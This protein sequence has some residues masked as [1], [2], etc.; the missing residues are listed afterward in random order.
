MKAAS[1]GAL[2]ALEDVLSVVRGYAELTERKRGTFHRKS[3]AFL[4]FHEDPAGLF[5]YVKV[6]NDF[7][8]YRVSTPEERQA[9]LACVEGILAPTPRVES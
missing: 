8:R 2:D 4:H 1:V 7:E 9:L 3:T 5:A 6:G